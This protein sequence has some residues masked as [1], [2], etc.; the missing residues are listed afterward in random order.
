MSMRLQWALRQPSAV[1]CQSIQLRRIQPRKI[2][3]T[4]NAAPVSGSSTTGASSK[5][6]PNS[7]RTGVIARK[8]GMTA[9]WN[10]QGARI[11]VTVLQVCVLARPLLV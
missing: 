4:V 8:R 1:S 11:P 9:L 7:I 2:H 3:A 10:D 5:W 6:T